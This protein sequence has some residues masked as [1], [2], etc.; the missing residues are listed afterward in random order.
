M[1]RL[2]KRY[3]VSAPY[4]GIVEAQ[5]AAKLDLDKI[6]P[7][8]A[9]GLRVAK[10]RGTARSRNLVF[11]QDV[12][13][14]LSLIA[15]L[16]ILNVTIEA[17]ANA[18]TS[19]KW[20]EHLRQLLPTTILQT[21]SMVALKFISKYFA[22]VKAGDPPTARAILNLREFSKLCRSP[23]TVNL[24]EIWEVLIRIARGGAYWV[25]A[26][27]RHYFHQFRLNKDIW[28]YFGVVCGGMAYVW[29]CMAMGWSWSP[30]IAQVTSWVMI[31]EACFR[32]KILKP[33]D[34]SH[35]ENPPSYVETADVFIVVWYDN[36]FASFRNS[37]QRDEGHTG[38]MW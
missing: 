12:D 30:R 38:C 13:L 7:K 22:V 10:I 33:E 23:N 17:P 4:D 36:L 8:V 31:L 32:C 27:W 19:E 35:L 14:I 2:F 37:S 15:F 24:P 34:Y 6:D 21:F 25:V 20:R 16:S 3:G 1:F 28:K 5:S 11:G 26:D 9:G 18:Q 29:T